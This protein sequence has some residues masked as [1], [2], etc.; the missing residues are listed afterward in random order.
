MVVN[1]NV[2]VNVDMNVVVIGVVEIG[3]DWDWD[4]DCGETCDIQPLRVVPQQ[5]QMIHGLGGAAYR[6]G[7]GL[8]NSAASSY[9][10]GLVR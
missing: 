3:I 4:W 9:L 10:S 7:L 6:G 8:H 2:N 1:V 5:E